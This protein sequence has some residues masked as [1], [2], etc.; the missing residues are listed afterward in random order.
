MDREN[1]ENIILNNFLE[2]NS[3]EGTFLLNNKWYAPKYG[4]D[5][6]DQIIEYLQDEKN[7]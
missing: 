3:Y 2:C 1:I 4:C 6:L 5:T 7:I